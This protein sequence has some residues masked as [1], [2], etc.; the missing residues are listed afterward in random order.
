[1][2]AEMAREMDAMRVGE[3]SVLKGA[4]FLQNIILAAGTNYVEHRLGRAPTGILA[5]LSPASPVS[6]AL[7]SGYDPARYFAVSNPLAASLTV[8][9][10]VF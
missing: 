6:V 4:T 1:M 2:L 10:L 8:S 5:A 3:S 7:P 9:F